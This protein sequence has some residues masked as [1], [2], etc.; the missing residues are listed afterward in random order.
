MARY[1]DLDTGAIAYATFL[2]CI[3]LILIILLVRALCFYW[4]EGENDRKLADAH[5]VSADQ[6]ISEQKAQISGYGVAEV[7]VA[8][9]AD[10]QEPAAPKLEERIHIPVEKAKELLLNELGTA[11][12]EPST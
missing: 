4:V 11:D 2:S 1:D 9:P 3:L 6:V 5:Y 12:P 7:E 8:A 10:S